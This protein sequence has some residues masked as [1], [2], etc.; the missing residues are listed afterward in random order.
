M[1]GLCWKLVIYLPLGSSE[2]TR[3]APS[4]K[5]ADEDI[6]RLGRKLLRVI[7]SQDLIILAFDVRRCGY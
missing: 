1:G 2:T 4:F 3:E 5:M 7:D 6:V